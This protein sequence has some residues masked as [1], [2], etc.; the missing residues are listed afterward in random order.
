ME[1]YL[2]IVMPIFASLLLFLIPGRVT[3]WL[4]T[5]IYGAV[6]ALTLHLF[7]RVR[8]AG[9][10]I[11]T[12]SSGSFL[13]I[14][15]Y[16][17]LTAAVFLVLIAFI[18]LCVFIYTHSPG[19]TNKLFS[20]LMTVLEGLVMLIFLSRDLFNIYVAVEV[21][22]IV[23][24]I[25]IMYKKESRSIYDGLVYLLTSMTGM[26]FFLLGI[27]MIYRQFG[28]LDFDGVAA[29]LANFGNGGAS[30]A[31]N[32]GSVLTLA[33]SAGP[34]MPGGSGGLGMAGGNGSLALPYALIMTGVCLKCAMVPMHFWLPLAHGT[35]SALSGV[36]ALLSGIYVKSGIY[37]FVRVQELFSPAVDTVAF[38]FWLGVITSIAGII[39]AVCQSDIKLILAYHTIS[40]LGLIMAGLS[41]GSPAAQA[42]A[43]LHIINHALFKSLLFLSAGLLVTAYGTR[44][45]YKIRGVW[46]NM[47]AVGIAVAAGIL[48]I[49]GAPF[50]NGSISKYLLAQGGSIADYAFLVINFGTALSFVKFGKMLFGEGKPEKTAVGIRATAVVLILSALCLATG[51]FA[52]PMVRLIFEMNLEIGALGYVK[53][54]LIWAVSFLAAYLVYSK[55][56]SRIPRLK[57]G[58]DFNLNFNQ[59]ILCTGASFLI[60]LT[61]AHLA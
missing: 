30:L 24:A 3:T 46:K 36:S 44:N 37:L 57:A 13:G 34:V 15:L 8:F 14:T 47:P 18:F 33:G 1:L 49:T 58:L 39:M 38:F 21:A 29:A 43:M 40:Q 9:E 10:L 2:L 61:A 52:G 42:G 25:L 48:G 35:P 55:I 27:G 17:D 31:G 41:T 26:M 20:F 50:F 32:G 22:T 51:I 4:C 5:G 59:M 12:K 53:K 28:V 56:L 19:R 45:V 60:L 16:C 23:C 54:A 11:T 6:L 7:W